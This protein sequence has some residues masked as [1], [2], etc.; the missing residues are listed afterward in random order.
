MGFSPSI[1]QL[2]GQVSYLNQVLIFRQILIL[3]KIIHSLRAYFFNI[4][5]PSERSGKIA[6]F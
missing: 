1:L 4:Y 5:L 2:K 3:G 6:R